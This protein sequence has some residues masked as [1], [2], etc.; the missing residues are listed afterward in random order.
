MCIN[1][2]N[3]GLYPEN[4][5][6]THTMTIISVTYIAVSTTCNSN[7]TREKIF[8]WFHVR[9]T[10][11]VGMINEDS[12]HH[13]EPENTGKGSVWDRLVT[14]FWTKKW[15]KENSIPPSTTSLLSPFVPSHPLAKEIV[16]PTFWVGFTFQFFLC[17][18]HFNSQQGC[19]NVPCDSVQDLLF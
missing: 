7:T 14:S 4:R 13:G 12:S 16:L 1:S 18:N 19:F 6:I 11:A 9:E 5:I 8:I 17:A 15:R 3:P 2:S 10:L